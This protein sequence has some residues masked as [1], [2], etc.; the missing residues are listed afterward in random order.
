MKKIVN[1]L[2][3]ITLIFLCINSLVFAHKEWV[4]QYIV[5]E[6]Y[7]FLDGFAS[8][9]GSEAIFRID[10]PCKLSDNTCIANSGGSII[11]QNKVNAGPEVTVLEDFADTLLSISVYFWEDAIFEGDTVNFLKGS[12]LIYD[13]TNPPWSGDSSEIS[14]QS[15]KFYADTINVYFVDTLTFYETL[16]TQLIGNYS[17]SIDGDS[18]FTYAIII[19]EN[20]PQQISDPANI[21]ISN[22]SIK[23]NIS[24]N[25][26]I[27]TYN[28]KES[29]SISLLL[30]NSNGQLVSTIEK[31]EQKTKGEN[32]ISFNASSL[33]PGL[34]YFAIF[35]NRDIIAKKFIIIRLEYEGNPEP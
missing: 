11:E 26:V 14:Y 7:K 2:I 6:A 3:T 24:S 15:K 19:N 1:F 33:S 34:Y 35:D 23:P 31:N 21:N 20:N 9:N 10:S 12:H 4:H 5:K 16:I 28:L 22:F 32:S 29:S 18:N 13:K 25:S 17:Y 8:E 27:I 30:C